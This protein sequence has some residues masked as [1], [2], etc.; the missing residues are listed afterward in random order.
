MLY[1]AHFALLLL[2]FFVGKFIG[3]E[4]GLEEALAMIRRPPVVEDDIC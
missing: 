2:A 4:E 3:R 1:L